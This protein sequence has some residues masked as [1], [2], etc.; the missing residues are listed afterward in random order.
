MDEPLSNLDAK[1]RVQMRAEI[2]KL[3]QRPRRDDDLRHARPGRGDDDGRPRRRHAQGRAAAGRRPADAL[4]PAGQPLRRRLHR[5]PRDEHARGDARAARTATL[6]AQIGDA[7]ASQLDEETLDARPALSE[8]RRQARDPRHPAR[9]PRGRGARAATRRPTRRLQRPRRAARGAR[10]RDHGALR[11]RR[12][13]RP[14]P[15]TTR[16]LAA[17]RRRG[18]RRAADGAARTTIIVGRFGARSRVKE[19]DDVE[20]AVDTRALHFFD[21]DT[22]LGIYDE[23]HE[24]SN[25]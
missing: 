10:L 3:Q 19:G 4:R 25:A 21:P 14:R 6:A 17:G 1:L 12:A 11:D 13:A 5:Q 20:V 22:G 9:G 2:A 18:R 8:L 7:D 16:E 23:R 15:T 24:R